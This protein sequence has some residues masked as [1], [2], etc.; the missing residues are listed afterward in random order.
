MKPISEKFD[1]RRKL[2]TDLSRMEKVCF[3]E[4]RR[5]QRISRRIAKIPLAGLD[6][7]T[8]AARIDR[9]LNVGYET[10]FGIQPS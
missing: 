5:A 6:A 3:P 2:R 1:G 7:P 10:A 8:A 4:L 9:V